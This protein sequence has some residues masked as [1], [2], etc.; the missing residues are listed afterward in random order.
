M[1]PNLQVA[2]RAD[3]SQAMGTGHVRRCLALSQALTGFDA[4]TLFVCRRHD[5]VSEHAL[6]SHQAVVWLGQ[7][8]LTVSAEGDLNG[9]D[10]VRSVYPNWGLVR[11]QQDADETIAALSPSPPNWLVVDHYAW[12]ARWHRRVSKALGCKIMV[13]DDLG[14]RPLAADLLLD[15]NLHSDHSAKYANCLDPDR[16]KTRFLFGPRYALLSAHYAKARKYVFSEQVRSIGI[17]MGGTDPDDLSSQALRACREVAQFDGDVVLVSSA[18][19]PHH[20]QRQALAAQW[21]RTRVISDLPDLADFFSRHDLQIG[22]GGGAAW[23]RCCIGVPTL[24]FAIAANQQAVLPQLAARG[25]VQ[26]VELP[27]AASSLQSFGEQIRSLI[28]NS[29][30]RLDLSRLASQLVDGLGANRVAA[31]IALAVS[32]DLTLRRA[33]LDDEPLLL[34]WSNDEQTR[35]NAFNPE[36]IL[37]S[38]H[39]NWLRSKLS[40]PNACVFLIAQAN[41]GIPVGTI[42]FD[43]ETNEHQQQSAK[44]W[45]LS[46]SLDKAFRGFGLGSLLVQMG[47]E[48]MNK[49]AT[50]SDLVKA[51]VKVDNV[52]SIKIFSSLLFSQ[53]ELSHKGATAYQFHKPLSTP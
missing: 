1:A 28:S 9:A 49:N 35:R 27:S 14:D 23:E 25:A 15:Q 30:Q 3:A 47:L 2:F 38:T 17:F 11:W 4:K 32:P 36:L 33:T 6:T 42:R 48:M 29:I 34:N 18:A 50:F 13:I 31:A 5:Q 53:T 8:D 44:V 39:A 10:D 19:S 43:R 20:A 37:E 46:Y 51:G 21:P 7:P 26:L 52:P 45:W 40:K 22:S 24:A 16:A 41:N 12:D